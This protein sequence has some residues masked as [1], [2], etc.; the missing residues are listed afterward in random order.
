[1]SP[2]ASDGMATVVGGPLAGGKYHVT[3][4]FVGI[5]RWSPV[6]LAVGATG[7][8]QRAAQVFDNRR[9]VEAAVFRD[10]ESRLH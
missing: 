5:L 4:G 8:S 9:L 3:N 2:F 6:T 1:M 10:D 7:R